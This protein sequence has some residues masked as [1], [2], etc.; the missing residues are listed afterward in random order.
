MW[1]CVS[2]VLVAW[3][4]AGCNNEPEQR[5]IASFAPPAGS[6]DVETPNR[7]D[8]TVRELSSSDWSELVDARTA[9]AVT[10]L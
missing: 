6:S 1:R 8:D 9:S 10:Q 5:R 4:V 7:L 2:A 3:L